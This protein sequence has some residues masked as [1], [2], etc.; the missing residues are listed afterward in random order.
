MSSIISLSEI[1]DVWGVCDHNPLSRKLIDI[2]S[3]LIVHRDGTV[4]VQSLA[5][6]KS[7]SNEFLTLD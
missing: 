5:I 1:Q 2:P 4:R 6:D 7:I 3:V